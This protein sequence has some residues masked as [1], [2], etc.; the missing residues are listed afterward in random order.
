M[1]PFGLYLHIPFCRS[2]CIYCDFS[3]Y[4]GM[5]R[6][7][8]A[9]IGKMTEELKNKSFIL[10]RRCAST[11]YVGGGTPSVLKPSLFSDLMHAAK[12][13]FPW[14]EDSEI[15]VEMNPGTITD[16]F[17][18]AARSSGVNRISLG[19]QSGNDRLLKRIGRIH[20]ESDISRAVCQ[21]REYGF[22]NYNIDMMIGLPEQTVDDVRDTLDFFMNLKPTHISCYS[23]IVEKGTPLYD[24]INRGKCDLPDED[25][26]RDMFYTADSILENEG[27]HRYEIS[28]YA[29]DGFCCQHNLDCWHRCEYLGIGVAAASL[30]GNNRIKNPETISAYLNGK[31]PEISSLTPEDERFETIMLGLRLTEGLSRIDFEQKFGSDIELVYPH[32][33]RKLIACGLLEWHGVY[34]RCTARGL[35]LQNEVLT[36]FM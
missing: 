7:Q 8:Y 24:D 20:N 10:G 29:K 23:L 22:D 12:E 31:S 4:P 2:K 15:S 25:T 5:D 16:D 1:T 35:D 6:W 3:S 34:L 21:L 11:V 32:V 30:I 19:A 36:E 14:N 33:I 13:T 17:L 28:N 26:E 27:Y 18:N 9:V